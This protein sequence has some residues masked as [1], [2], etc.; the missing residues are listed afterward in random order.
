MVPGGPAEAARK[1]VVVGTGGVTGVYFP[2]GGALCRVVNES[3]AEHGVRC[4][5]EATAGSVHNVRAVMSGDI[6]I[7]LVQADVQFQAVRGEGPFE[8]APRTALRM[9]FSLHDEAFTVVARA[10][11]GIRWFSDL[12]GRRV[13]IGNVGS[14]QRNAMDMLMAGLGWDETMFEAALE[15]SSRDQAQALCDGRVDAIVF[16]AGHPNA[17]IHEAI[18]GCDGVLI[19]LRSELIEALTDGAPYLSPVRIDASVY[20]QPGAEVTSFGTVATVV[21]SESLDP[22]VAHAFTRAVFEGFGR[23]VTQHPAL[24]GL[25]RG[26]MVSDGFHAPMHEGAARYF[27]EAGLID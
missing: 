16:V 24:A 14:G 7:G 11:S 21:A 27:K 18:R 4:S 17:S 8:D 22:D 12:A 23:V 2:A 26:G 1:F 5:V 15:L 25:S 6:D 20:G 10:E 19:P 13:N 9:L 3:R